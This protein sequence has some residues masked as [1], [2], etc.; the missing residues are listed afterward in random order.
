MLT[1]GLARRG[2]PGGGMRFGPC[3]DTEE[4]PRPT[5]AAR[6]AVR[7]KSADSNVEF[8]ELVPPIGR[9]G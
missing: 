8:A 2:V 1:R 7:A 4:G 6:R 9:R 5:L 3:T